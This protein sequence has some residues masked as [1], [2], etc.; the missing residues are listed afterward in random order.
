[1]HAIS[2]LPTFD[3]TSTNTLTVKSGYD[4]YKIDYNDILYIK[5][6]GEYVIYNTVKKNIMSYQTLKSLEKTLPPDIFIRIHRSY[7]V[8]KNKVTGLVSRNLL[9]DS[10]KLPIS[11]SYFDTVKKELF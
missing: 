7:I 2:K 1:M 6:E 3:K 5:S 10:L 11:D 8:N 9:L 4:I